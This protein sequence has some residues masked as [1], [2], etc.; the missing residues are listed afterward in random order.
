MSITFRYFEL[1][2]QTD[3]FKIFRKHNASTLFDAFVKIIPGYGSD[4]IYTWTQVEAKAA[5]FDTQNEAKSAL[6]ETIKDYTNNY[7]Y[8]YSIV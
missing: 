5:T 7:S 3:M 4:I 8:T 1:T 6:E 2:N